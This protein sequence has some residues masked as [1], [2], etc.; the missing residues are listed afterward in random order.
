MSIVVL[1]G[2]V[3]AAF[4]ANA[5]E[6]SQSLEGEARKELSEL[7]EKKETLI[8]YESPHRIKET[9]QILLE[10]LGDRYIVL[11][12]ELTKLNEEKIYGKLSELLTLDFA[13]IKGE[14]VLVVEGKEEEEISEE[15]IKEKINYFL[16]KGINKK[17]TTDLVSELYNIKK[18]KIKDL[19]LKM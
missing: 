13:T 4:T 2:C 7:K 9:L 17:T 15:E 14:I 18:N 12:R 5:G 1:V 11:Q 3:C 16:A 6:A 19:I 8:F 10:E